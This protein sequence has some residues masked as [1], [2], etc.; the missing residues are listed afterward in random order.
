LIIYFFHN[1]SLVFRDDAIKDTKPHLNIPMIITWC[2][3]CFIDHC[4]SSRLSSQ[5]SFLCWRR[6]EL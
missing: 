5:E 3:L 6:G 1:N 4:K 2:F